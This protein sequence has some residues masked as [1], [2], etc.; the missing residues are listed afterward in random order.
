MP[1]SDASKASAYA[2]RCLRMGAPWAYYD[3]WANSVRLLYCSTG[4]T[5]YNEEAWEAYQHWQNEAC[6]LL[7]ATRDVAKAL[8]DPLHVCSVPQSVAI[9]EPRASL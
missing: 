3:G 9:Q 7:D 4:F 2:I 5:Q 6:G 1:A 8:Q